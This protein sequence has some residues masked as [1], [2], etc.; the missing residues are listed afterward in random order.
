MTFCRCA[1]LRRRPNRPLYGS[2][3]S[4]RSVRPSVL[5]RKRKNQIG[6][7][8]LI[9]TTDQKDGE[10]E[11]EVERR[12]RRTKMAER[13]YERTEKS[14]AKTT[15][16][17][18]GQRKRQDRPCAS[19]SLHGWGGTHVSSSHSPSF[20]LPRRNGVRSHSRRG[21]ESWTELELAFHLTVTFLIRLQSPNDSL[22]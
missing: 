20:S 3:P 8:W 14:T 19:I 22:H 2:C 6:E 12:R 17:T 13:T 5:T 11:V 15:E 21:T 4:V 9:T 7:L 16:K 1:G 10:Y 18:N